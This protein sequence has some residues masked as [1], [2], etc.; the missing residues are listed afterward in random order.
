MR[1]TRRRDCRGEKGAR[2]AQ[3]KSH[4]ELEVQQGTGNLS[5]I[6]YS[7]LISKD[8]SVHD[9]DVESTATIELIGKKKI[10]CFHVA[11]EGPKI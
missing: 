3:N 6:F 10:T 4:F 1:K 7:Q 9:F 2:E 8:S 11:K 5:D